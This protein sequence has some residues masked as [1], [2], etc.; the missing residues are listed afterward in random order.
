VP[1]FRARLR[2]DLSAV[3]ALLA[4]G[5]LQAQVAARIPLDR[6]AAAME[7]AESRTVLGKVV[8]VAAAAPP[9]DA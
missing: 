8:L 7:L 5:R 6:A 1:R 3:F 4:D 9:S 2:K